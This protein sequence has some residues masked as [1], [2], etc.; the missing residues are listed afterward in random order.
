[1]LTGYGALDKTTFTYNSQ[2]Y[3]IQYLYQRT[4]EAHGSSWCRRLKARVSLLWS[5]GWPGS[6]EIWMTRLPADGRAQAS[7][8]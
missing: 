3:E 8:Y 7:I 4:L 5:G 6:P 1:M 2:S